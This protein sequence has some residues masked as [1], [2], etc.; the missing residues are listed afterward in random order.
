MRSYV[1]VDFLNR[2]CTWDVL[3]VTQ[4]CT[5]YKQRNDSKELKFQRVKRLKI[6]SF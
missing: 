6:L 2:I 4:L 1:F 3:H 5:I